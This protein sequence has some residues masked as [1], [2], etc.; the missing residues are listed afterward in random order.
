MPL[1]TKIALL[2]GCCLVIV[3]SLAGC[4]ASAP[5]DTSGLRTMTTERSWEFLALG[6]SDVVR[7]TVLGHPDL[8]T[9][10]GGQRVDPQGKLHLPM[11]G[12]VDV[13]GLHVA[14][15]NERLHEAY[16]K[17]LREPEVTAEV[18]AFQSRGFYAFGQF[19]EPGFKVMERPLNALEAVSVA[20]AL[21]RGADRENVFLLRPHADRLEV[22]RFDMKTPGGPAMVAVRPGDL[23][24]V[25]QT[26]FEDFQE[27]ILP[28][29]AGLGYPAFQATLAG[30][31]D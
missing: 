7:V 13:K 14:Q 28:I 1:P 22:H 11:V 18:V 8:S 4:A 25:R 30:L 17:Y 20:G 15:L 10:T 24:Y 27:D 3:L 29:L 21:Q 12:G 5:R 26:G 23:I 6:P 19:A 16:A 2:A 31:G 9:T